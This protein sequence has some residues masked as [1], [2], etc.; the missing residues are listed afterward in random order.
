MK[1]NRLKCP[2]CNRT[3]S[4]KTS[5]TSYERHI[6]NHLAKVKL[7]FS[8][9]EPTSAPEEVKSPIE[10]PEQN[11]RVVST[12]E[13]E[14]SSETRKSNRSLK[15]SCKICLKKFTYRKSYV[16]HAKSHK[17][18]ESE[19]EKGPKSLSNETDEDEDELPPRS[20]QCSQCGKLF[21]TKRNLTRH[22]ST[23]S[24]IRFNC[25]Y[26]EK[27]FS[28]SDKLKEHANSRH[29]KEIYGTSEDDDGLENDGNKVI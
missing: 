24:N 4:I 6:A 5:V 1:S 20:F 10:T 18:C 21:K 25:L 16:S 2:H 28:R 9:L 22:I 3:F 7:S 8:S 17:E 15:Y 23:H 14:N 19:A 29:K 13:E 26:C 12:N 27:V 11:D